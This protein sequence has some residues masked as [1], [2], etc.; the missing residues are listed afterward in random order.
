VVVPAGAARLKLYT[1]RYGGDG[2]TI[3]VGE[4]N[5]SRRP[6]LPGSPVVS[7]ST[8]SGR[9]LPLSGLTPFYP[10]RRGQWLS[11]V[12]GGVRYLDRVTIAATASSS[13]TATVAIE[14]LL[15]VPVSAGAQVELAA[16]KIEGLLELTADPQWSVDDQLTA[17]F[18]FTVTEAK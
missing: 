10:I 15:R 18:Q 16:P 12:Q 11:I 3:Y 13:G 7:S 17:F 5:V 2:G 6:P 8:A 4:P 14:N 9:S 1:V